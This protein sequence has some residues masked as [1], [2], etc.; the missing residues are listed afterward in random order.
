MLACV[1]KGSFILGSDTVIEAKTDIEMEDLMPVLEDWSALERI[2]WALDIFGDE[3][4][5]STSFGIHSSVMLHLVCS[6]RPEIP[7]IFVDTG[8]LFKE[9]YRYARDLTER[10]R[11]NLYKVHPLMSAAEHEALYGK[12]WLEGREGIERYNQVRKVEPMNRALGELGARAWLTG[13]RRSQS[14]S[15]KDLRVLKR[16]KKTWKIHPIVDWG[17]QEVKDYMRTFELPV[18]PLQ[19]SGYFSVGDTHSTRRL[20]Q[21]MKVEETRF[22]G[23]KRECGLHEVSSQADFQI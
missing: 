22:G 13:L 16:Q 18:H 3:L 10:M 8:Y 1:L 9:T 15:R 19:E 6:A 7:V 20:A 5:L 2:C 21:G 12:L 17:D 4:T 23:L 14:S 11:L